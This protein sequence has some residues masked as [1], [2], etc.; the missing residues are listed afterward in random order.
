MVEVIGTNNRILE[1]D[2]STGESKV[3]SISDNDRKLY[4]GGKGLGLKLLAERLKPRIDPLGEENVLVIMTGVYMSTG[5]PCSARFT[6]VTKSPLTQIILTSSCGGPFG[7]ALKTAG[8]DGLILTGKASNPS[9]LTIDE[10]VELLDAANLWGMDTEQT[11]LELKSKGF[12]DALVIGPAGENQV[13]FANAVTGHRFLGRGGVGAVMGSKNLKAIAV[14]GKKIKIIAKHPEK[15]QE[16]KKLGTAYIN[17]NSITGTAYRNF[18]TNSHVLKCNASKILPVRNFSSGSHSDAKNISGELYAEKFTKRHHTCKPCSILCGHEGE[19]NGKRMAIP[20]YESTGL[21]GS[22]LSVFDPVAVAEWNHLCGLLGL[23]SIT[24]GSVLGWTMEATEKG[25]VASDLSFGKA[26][27]IAQ[28]ITDTAYRRGLGNE[29]ANGTRSLSQKF[30][31]T[32]FAAH[33]KGLELAAYDPRGA[34]GQGLAYATANRGGCH[35][36]APVFT[37]EGIMHYLLPHTSYAKVTFTDYFEN[38]FAAVNSMH[39]CQFTSFAYMLEPYVAKTTPK[40]L[41][42]LTMQ[43]MPKVALALMDISMYSKSYQ[44]ITGIKLSQAEMLKAGK[45]IHILERIMNTR[46]GISAKDD[47]LPARFLNEGRLDDPKKHVVPLGKM[48]KKYYKVKGFDAN[49]IPKESTIK[50]MQ[51]AV[52]FK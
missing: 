45:R 11:Q 35:L 51:I 33:V 30:G 40:F 2:L 26:D 37:L 19:F 9:L 5:V 24:M 16:L 36:S 13:L 20:E 52:N 23:D 27:N 48:L 4:L 8:Y 14:N 17:R 21:L 10:K 32:E 29:L 39:G 18:G 7:M 47:I 25:L 1:V 50:Q 41:L 42:S 6:A 31:G 3:I 49:G 46:E 22:N 38:M 12:G 15:L 34:W 44:A 43:I 28:T